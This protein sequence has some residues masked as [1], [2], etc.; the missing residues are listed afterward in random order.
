VRCSIIKRRNKERERE[1]ESWW[2]VNI[3]F[4]ARIFFYC[5]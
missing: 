5:G 4:N 1:T 3:I 2:W